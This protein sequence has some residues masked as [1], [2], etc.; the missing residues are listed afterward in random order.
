MCK[1]YLKFTLFLTLLTL[2][3]LS[4]SAAPMI[5]VDKA[6]MDLGSI[7]AG[8]KKSIKHSFIIKNTGDDTLKIE[9]VKPG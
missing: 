1:K 6:D 8:N 2:P 3:A 7:P 9:K 4:P 5:E